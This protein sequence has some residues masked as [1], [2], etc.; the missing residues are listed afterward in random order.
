MADFYGST[1]LKFVT[2]NTAEA[3]EVAMNFMVTSIPAFF[4]FKDG[5]CIEQFVGADKVKLEGLVKQLKLDIGDSEDSVTGDSKTPTPTLKLKYDLGFI[6]FKPWST[7]EILFENISNMSKIANKIKEIVDT[8]KEEE[9]T[10]LKSLMEDFKM[11]GLNQK[12]LA[13][14]FIIAQKCEEKDVFAVFDFLR[15]CFITK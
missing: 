15:C 14:L 10:E 2:V 1:K 9:L 13:Q 7:H 6:Q 12:V 5:K 11:T 3:R 8:V 4:I